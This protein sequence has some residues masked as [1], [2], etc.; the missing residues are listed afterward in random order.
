MNEFE[1]VS[2][3]NKVFKIL[4]ILYICMFY[5]F[6]YFYIILLKTYLYFNI[7]KP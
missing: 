6:S 4:K 5:G 7:H 1:L 3:T 2:M